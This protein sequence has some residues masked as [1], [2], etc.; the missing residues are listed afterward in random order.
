PAPPPPARARG[1][2]PA[3]PPPP[4]GPGPP[5]PPRPPTPASP[6][7]GP[8]P[9][10]AAPSNSLH[11][12]PNQRGHLAQPV[13]NSMI[14]H[15]TAITV[16]RDG[17]ALVDVR[18]VVPQPVDQV[19][20]PLVADDL[21]ANLEERVKIFPAVR[22]LHHAVSGQLEQAVAAHGVITA[23]VHVET[24]LRALVQRHIVVDPN[25]THPPGEPEHGVEV[26]V[27]L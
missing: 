12:L 8:P 16:Q 5:P 14:P 21:L 18:Q 23:I 11:T 25:G 1:P 4:P 7:P 2:T 10:P 9:P 13:S 24:N 17:P 19:I 26:D 3:T 15:H 20:C 27:A 6:P 22:N